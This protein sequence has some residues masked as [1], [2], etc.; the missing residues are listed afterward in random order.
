MGKKF[1][2]N[3]KYRKGFRNDKKAKKK[4]GRKLIPFLRYEHL[5]FMQFG[6]KSQIDYI[7]MYLSKEMS[8]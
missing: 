7:C 4:V 6:A 2:T 1:N 3:M 8:N 5:Y